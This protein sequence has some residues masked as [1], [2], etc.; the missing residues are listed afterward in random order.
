MSYRYASLL[1]P[2]GCWVSIDQEYLIEEPL[3]TDIDPFRDDWKAHNVLITEFPLP[4]EKIQSLQLTDVQ[5]MKKR[6]ELYDK[7][8]EMTLNVKAERYESMI[9]EELGDKIR[10]G[11]IKNQ[12]VLDK[13]IQKYVKYVNG[14]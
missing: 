13:M 6:K 7:L 4:K 10:L 5:E 3:E 11:K 1:R 2:P 8:Y 9:K 14:D 12:T